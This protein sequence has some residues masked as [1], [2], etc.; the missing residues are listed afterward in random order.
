MLSTRPPPRFRS[1]TAAA[2]RTRASS[3]GGERQGSAFGHSLPWPC[4]I[5]LLT[6]YLKLCEI[7]NFYRSHIL[8]VP[9]FSLPLSFAALFSFL[10]SCYPLQS[11]FPSYLPLSPPS[12]SSS[13]LLTSSPPFSLPLTLPPP[14]YRL[15]IQ[16]GIS[17]I[18]C[19]VW[20][21][22]TT[23]PSSSLLEILKSRCSS[24]CMEYF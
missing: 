23:I 13:L 2:K 24:I 11:S 22:T 6:V 15:R 10:Y 16:S 8:T 3:R 12:S 19:I 14:P 7:K 1:S 20:G 18:L 4:L 5:F 17:N 9:T 21:R